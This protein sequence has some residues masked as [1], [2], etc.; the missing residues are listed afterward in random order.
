MLETAPPQAATP[1]LRVIVVEWEFT[2]TISGND[3]KQGRKG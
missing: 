1:A 3:P 2:L